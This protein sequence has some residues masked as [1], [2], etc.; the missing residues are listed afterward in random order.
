MSMSQECLQ[1][2]REAQAICRT[3]YDSAKVLHLIQD[4][5]AIDKGDVF[6]TFWQ[7]FLEIEAKPYNPSDF[8]N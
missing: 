1:K 2:L 8:E 7:Q 6:N 4:A 3:S 5:I